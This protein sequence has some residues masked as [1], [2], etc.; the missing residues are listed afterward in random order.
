MK[1][2]FYCDSIFTIGGVQRVLAVIAKG[3]ASKHQV[4]IL[5]ADAP[6]LENTAL[7]GLNEEQID[8]RYIRYPRLPFYEYYPCK[9]YSFLYKKFLP[10]NRLTIKGYCYSSFPGSYRKRLL[11]ALS[12]G[13]YDLIV[14]V[15]VYPSFYLSAIKKHLR[16]KVVGWLHTSYHAFFELPG[17]WLWKSEQ[18]FAYQMGRLDQVV[19]LTH[20]DQCLYR[21]KMGLPCEVIY[22]PLALLPEGLA[23][24]EYKKFL[25]VGRM[26]H[27]TKGFDLLIEAFAVFASQ[28]KEWTLDIVGEGPE[29]KRLQ[30]M[31]RQYELSSRVHIYPFTQDIQTYYAGSS[32]FVLSSRW[33]GFPLVLAEAMAHG[34]PI[35]ASDIP[36]VK[37]L[38]QGAG[39]A[40][41]FHSEDVA[42][43]ADKM[44]CMVQQNELGQMGKISLHKVKELQLPA[45]LQQWEV[46]FSEWSDDPVADK[47]KQ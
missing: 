24:P 37:E 3:L 9:A 26:S 21:E 11:R 47:K 31:I 16:A 4:T 46:L 29:E 17:M 10:K 23:K 25:A 36:V 27:L 32:I 19:V 45:I 33:E 30:D 1:I 15:H 22:N 18:R 20:H 35:L 6:E 13:G 43:L 44:L 2:C 42:D 28:D 40:C 5:T 14:G 41:L 7:Y 8:Y 39:N 34:L 12:E 38:L